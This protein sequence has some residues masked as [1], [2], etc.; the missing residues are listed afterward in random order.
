MTVARSVGD[1][2][3]SMW[4]SRSTVWTVCTATCM[5]RNCSMRWD[6]SAM[7]TGSWD[8]RSPRPRRWPVSPM[9]STT[10]YTALPATMVC[11][12]FISPRSQRTGRNWVEAIEVEVV[13]I[14][15]SPNYF[16]TAEC[17]F[18]LTRVAVFAT[19]P[20]DDGSHRF[21]PP[22]LWAYLY[23]PNGAALRAQLSRSTP[24]PMKPRRFNGVGRPGT[25]CARATGRPPQVGQ[26]CP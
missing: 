6:W 22:L 2:L 25:C 15:T 7:C 9:R 24:K 17:L 26:V 21:G 19:N 20:A 12:R 4:C 13:E 16:V 10:R 8:C 23:E 18:G 5:C 14:R 11:R 1:V 3:A